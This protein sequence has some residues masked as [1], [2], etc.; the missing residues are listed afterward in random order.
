MYPG[1]W[2]HISM[3]TV[4]REVIVSPARLPDSVGRLRR[5]WPH[6]A[7]APFFQVGV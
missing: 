5:S 6:V 1:T 7:S 3:D 4:E 2:G